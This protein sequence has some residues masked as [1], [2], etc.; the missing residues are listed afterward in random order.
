MKKFLINLAFAGTVT[1]SMTASAVEIADT[2]VDFYGSLRIM[3]ERVESTNDTEFKDA[4]SRIGIKGSRDLGDG[5]SAFAKYEVAVDLD[6]KGDTIGDTR[7]SYIGLSD[8][9]GS[10][11][12]GRVASPFYDT[13]AYYG[14]YM[15]WDSAPVYYTIDGA[16]R[17]GQSIQYSS[18]DM[19]GFQLKGL[20]QIDD[21]DNGD[22]GQTQL[23][24]TYSVGSVTF[25]AGYIDTAD[26]NNQYGLAVSYSGKGFYVNGAYMDREN[27]GSGFDGLIG[28]PSGKNLYT[29][30]FSS[31][32]AEAANKDFD[33]II[34][35]Y[36]YQ[37]HDDVLVWVEA[38][39][40]DG[41]LYGTLDSNVVNVGLNFNF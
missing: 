12:A 1:A 36:Q 37:L 16:S 15:W 34:L 23:G 2:G 9:W 8:D 18:P 29:V 41:S 20:V 28:V 27:V 25:G 35:A 26:D 31:Y 11:S 39:G 21:A 17:I 5:L 7:Y 6:D 33:A 10:F 14:D 3:L 19:N 13:V 38:M 32:E 24:A 22:K 40:W 4:S 30:G